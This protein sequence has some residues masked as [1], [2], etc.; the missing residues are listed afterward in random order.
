MKRR[1]FTLIE[2]LVV[3]AIIALLVA[4]LLPALGKAKKAALLVKSQSN[5]RQQ[6]TSAKSYQFDN[7]NYLPL[8]LA[9]T[10]GGTQVTGVS[11]EG[12]CTWSFGGKNCQSTWGFQAFDVEAADRPLNPYVYEEP[13][14]GPTFPA[15]MAPADPSRPVLDLPVFRDPGDKIG[16]Q[17]AGTVPGD[18]PNENQ[19]G[20]TC[21]D[22]VGTSYQFNVKWWDQPGISNLPF[23]RR[24]NQGTANMALGDTFSPSRFVWVHDEQ[25]DLVVNQGNVNF[26]LKNG[27]DDFNRSVMGFLDGHAAYNTVY[28]GAWG[29][30]NGRPSFWN[31][32]YTFIFENNIIP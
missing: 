8:T 28:P 32:Q 16:H 12:W 30:N 6:N 3:I 4:L 1:A 9:Y 19:D 20:S 22:D 5:I 26:R 15:R 31:A 25:A 11:L 14:D 17:G 7:K 2:L 21:Y 23:V 29:S 10:R 13:I 24:F 18:W 27:Y